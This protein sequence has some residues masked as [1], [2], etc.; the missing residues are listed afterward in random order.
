[1]SPLSSWRRGRGWK[2]LVTWVLPMDLVY[3]GHGGQPLHLGTNMSAEMSNIGH[4]TMYFV[5]Q[6]T[7]ICIP[8]C[9]RGQLVGEARSDGDKRVRLPPARPLDLP[10]PALLSSHWLTKQP[11]AKGNAAGN[12]GGGGG[13]GRTNRSGNASVTVVVRQAPPHVTAALSASE[14]LHYCRERRA[15]NTERIPARGLTELRVGHEHGSS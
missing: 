6:Y 1:M 14:G 10:R 12:E 8:E 2:R 5:T 9:E 11:S 4:K 15:S 3:H 7:A 13:V